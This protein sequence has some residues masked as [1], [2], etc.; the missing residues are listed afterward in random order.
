MTVTHVHCCRPYHINPST[1]HDCSIKIHDCGHH[2]TRIGLDWGSHSPAT[3]ST[4]NAK[5]TSRGGTSR[6]LSG[7]NVSSNF[8]IFIYKSNKITAILSNVNNTLHK[9]NMKEC[10]YNIDIVPGAAQ[11]PN[12]AS[13]IGQKDSSPTPVKYIYSTCR[14]PR[15]FIKQIT[16]SSHPKTT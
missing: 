6:V 9:G 1:S 7:K 3:S 4:V 15:S 8:Y 14:C 10:L 16:S 12:G 11:R 13:Q 5:G 2:D